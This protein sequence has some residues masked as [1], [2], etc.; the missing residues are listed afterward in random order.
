MKIKLFGFVDRWRL[1]NPEALEK[2]Y[3]FFSAVL[4]F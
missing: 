1:K 3:P 4:T 2:N